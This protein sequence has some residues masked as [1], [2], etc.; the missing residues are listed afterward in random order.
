[1]VMKNSIFWDITLKVNRR[2]GGIYRADAK[3]GGDMSLRN[4][5]G[6]STDEMT[7]YPIRYNSL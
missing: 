6:L 2:F 5:G 1:M 7:L 4:V 3:D